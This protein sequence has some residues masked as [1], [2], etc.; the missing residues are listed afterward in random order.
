MGTAAVD[1]SN[2]GA[3]ILGANQLVSNGTL[4]VSSSAPPQPTI[5][6]V[7]VVGTNLVVPV[8]TISGYSY[9]LQ[10]TTNLAPPSAW[11]NE[12]TN[13]GTGSTLILNVPFDPNEPQKFLRFWVY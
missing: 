11:F 12:S 13:A 2:S 8:E 10:S 5:A 6:P 7:T 1:V 4:S 3:L 9:V